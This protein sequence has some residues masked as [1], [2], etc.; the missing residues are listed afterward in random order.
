M[1]RSMRR[2]CD[3]VTCGEVMCFMVA[4]WR[5]LRPG[6]RS[7]VEVY[8]PGP[9]SKSRISAES[10]VA[11]PFSASPMVA[12]WIHWF[13]SAIAS[14]YV[15]HGRL[16]RLYVGSSRCHGQNGPIH[17]FQVSHKTVAGYRIILNGENG[18]RVAETL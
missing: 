16:G 4:C 7:D 1:K 9:A 3:E 2:A 10:K 8:P 13:L 17:T 15:A 11:N 5:W 14:H 6:R 18:A 12:P